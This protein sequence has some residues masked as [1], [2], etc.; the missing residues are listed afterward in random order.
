MSSDH[1]PS[2]ASL[3]IIQGRMKDRSLPPSAEDNFKQH[4]ENLMRLAED[5]KKLGMDDRQID[6]H[7]MEI[8]AEY[9]CE[10]A[11]NIKRLNVAQGK[12][13]IRDAS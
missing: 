7:V 3:K 6:D 2:R 13:P 8:F 12:P 11:A 10:L 4:Y 5:L 9:E 1:Q